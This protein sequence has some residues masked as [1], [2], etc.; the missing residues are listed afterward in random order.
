MKLLT[1]LR[2]LFQ[3][4]SIVTKILK[5]NVTD[6]NEPKTGMNSFYIL[7]VT[8]HNNIIINNESNIEEIFG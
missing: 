8:V 3:Y 5:G 7:L 6:V 2:N 1:L 4:V